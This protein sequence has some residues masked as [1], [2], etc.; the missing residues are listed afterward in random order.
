[1]VGLH[2]T[3]AMDQLWLHIQYAIEIYCLVIVLLR[4]SWYTLQAKSW[5][6]QLSVK[7]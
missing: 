1:M 7:L 5:N 6:T 3:G 2:A 4:L